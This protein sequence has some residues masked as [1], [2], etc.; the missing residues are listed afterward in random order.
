MSTPGYPFP[1]TDPTGPCPFDSQ[2]Y[3]EWADA[4]Q[5]G[6]GDPAPQARACLRCGAFDIGPQGIRVTYHDSPIP[7]FPA[8]TRSYRD[9]VTHNPD[10][11]SPEH[12]DPGQEIST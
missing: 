1:I 3:H 5:A 12:V 11:D 10:D 2:G 4:K 6:S 8:G 9:I 7:I